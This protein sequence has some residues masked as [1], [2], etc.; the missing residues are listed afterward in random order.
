MLFPIPDNISN[1]NKSVS[2]GYVN[3]DGVTENL[4][5]DY[6]SLNKIFNSD[7]FQQYVY[8]DVDDE[9]PDQIRSWDYNRAMGP[10]SDLDAAE[11]AI[12]E[13]LFYPGYENR[14]IGYEFSRD[15]GDPLYDE[16]IGYSENKVLQRELKKIMDQRNEFMAG[17]L[18]KTNLIPQAVAYT[19]PLN[20][21]AQKEQFKGL[22]GGIAIDMEKGGW[23]RFLKTSELQK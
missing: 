15:S 16:I 13:Q 3:G 20:N 11:K 14:G 6:N 5:A 8:E 1:Q 2:N 17:E 22:L 10:E 9:G 12:F 23:R 7:K 4:T 18:R 21:T 19:I